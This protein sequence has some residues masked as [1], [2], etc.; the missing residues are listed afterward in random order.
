MR[1]KPDSVSETHPY[2]QVDTGRSMISDPESAA[3]ERRH[4]W[5][6]GVA[7]GLFSWVVLASTTPGIPIVWDEGEYLYRAA[8]VASW[9]RLLLDVHSLQAGLNVLSGS[10]IH[11]HWSFV[12]SVEGHPSWSAIPI[13]L[14]KTLLSPWVSPLTAARL[15]QPILVKGRFVG[16]VVLYPGDP[17][18]IAHPS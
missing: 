17:A 13:V 2:I 16:R 6:F 11:D 18:V 3:A 4:E 12:V 5:L 7:M 14:G 15:G 9:F 1:C 8:D 10:V